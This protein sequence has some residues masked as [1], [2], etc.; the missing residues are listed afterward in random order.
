MSPEPARGRAVSGAQAPDPRLRS[1]TYAIPFEQVWR[2]A[3]QLTGGRLRGWRT[4]SADDHEGVI[5]AVSRG[6]GGAEHDVL[7]RIG[8]DADAQTIVEAEVTARRPGRDFGRA[9][10]RLR[11]LLSALDRAVAPAARGARWFSG[12]PA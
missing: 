8:L 11:R 9:E 7:L 12:R 3:L 6:L 5:E 1:R 10:R 2:A 4:V